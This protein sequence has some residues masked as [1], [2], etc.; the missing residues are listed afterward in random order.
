L[1]LTTQIAEEELQRLVKCLV[2]WRSGY[3]AQLTTRE[4]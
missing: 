2:K 3:A 4:A 1:S